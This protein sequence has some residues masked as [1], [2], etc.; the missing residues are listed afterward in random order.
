LSSIVAF[1]FG[2]ALLARPGGSLSTVINLLGLYLIVT[3]ALRLLQ[4]MDAWHRRRSDH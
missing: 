1:V 3:G 2:I 4:A